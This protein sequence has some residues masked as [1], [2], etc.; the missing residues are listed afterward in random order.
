MVLR[1]P[2]QM[3][4]GR[5]QPIW[6][7]LAVDD[8]VVPNLATTSWLIVISHEKRKPLYQSRHVAAPWPSAA[9]KESVMKN[10]HRDHPSE[11]PL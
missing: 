11:P 2:L 8:T 1:Y 7:G 10:K 5:I 3:Y 6:A 4:A 9:C